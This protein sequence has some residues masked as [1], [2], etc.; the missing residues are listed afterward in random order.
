MKLQRM[1]TAA[2][3]CAFIALA[4]VCHIF[5]AAIRDALSPNVVYVFP[6]YRLTDGQL[7]LVIPT[8]ALRHDELGGEYVLV[9]EMSQKYPERCYE[10]Q[11]REVRIYQIDG[12]TALIT[13]GVQT[14]DMVIIEGDVIGGERVMPELCSVPN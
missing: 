1:I 5:G 3:L 14:G 10:A 9:A 12:D 8:A 6:E 4:A 13:F 7:L 2:F 11:K